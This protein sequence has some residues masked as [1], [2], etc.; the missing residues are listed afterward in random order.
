MKMKDVLKFR[1]IFPF[2]IKRLGLRK[3]AGIIFFK[4]QFSLL[5]NAWTDSMKW[6]KGD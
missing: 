3:E 4:V 5:D 6:K 2:T 1:E